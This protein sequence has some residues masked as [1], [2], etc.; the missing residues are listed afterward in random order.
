M[1]GSLQP[2]EK[3]YFRKDGSRVP[4]LIGAANLDEGANRGVA[5]VLDL[6]ERK[7]AEADAHE[8]ERRYRETQTQLAHA[9]RVATMGQLTASIAH[10]VNQPIAATVANARA[11]LRWLGAEPPNLGEVRQALGRIARDGDRAGAVVGRIRAL[12]KKAPPGDERVEINAAI[13]EVIEFTRSEAVKSGV[14]AQ[15][16]LL[17]GL[18]LVR[19]DRVELQQVILN[20]VLNAFEAMSGISESPRELLIATNKTESGDVV[21]S[22]RDSGPGL[23]PAAF[24][25]LFEAFYTTKPNGIGLGLS[26]CRSIIEA[27]SGRL[28]AS[29]N[30][31]RGAVFQFTLPAHRDIATSQ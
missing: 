8:S 12:I 13:R 16:D 11:A 27:H 14:R 17:E 20:L 10:E 23:A 6:T 2:Y 31:A 24:E 4:V 15:T 7:R 3:E 18:P 29:A 28:W 21:V 9:N 30:E 26:I 25:R 19:G 1:T 5:F 22:V